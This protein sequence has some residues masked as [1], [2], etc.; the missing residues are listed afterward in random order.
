M[1]PAAGMVIPIAGRMLDSGFV[2]STVKSSSVSRTLKNVIF[3]VRSSK[4]RFPMLNHW[5]SYEKMPNRV[6]SKRSLHSPSDLLYFVN[7]QKNSVTKCYPSEYGTTNLSSD[8]KSN[9]LLS[10]LALECKTDTF[11]T[12]YIHVPLMV[13]K[14]SKSKHVCV[15]WNQKF[16]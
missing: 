12:L 1:S 7:R 3:K 16:K 14:S 6:Y 2:N 10:N 4:Y 5:Y 8:L 11:S 13:T 9:M 15:A